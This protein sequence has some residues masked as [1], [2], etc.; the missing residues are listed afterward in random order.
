MREVK[1]SFETLT[2]LWT[3]MDTTE[4]TIHY[5]YRVYACYVYVE[6]KKIDDIFLGEIKPVIVRYNAFLQYKKFLQDKKWQEFF[7]KL[8]E[9]LPNLLFFREILE[10]ILIYARYH[11]KAMGD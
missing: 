5:S 11:A 9:D 6:S 7:E 10:K 1:M 2:P 8:P 3:W 4:E